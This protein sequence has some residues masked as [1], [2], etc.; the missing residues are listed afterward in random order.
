MGESLTV[1]QAADVRAPSGAAAPTA[2]QRIAGSGTTEA[3]NTTKLTAGEMA[4]LLVGKTRVRVA[5]K[6][7]IGASAQVS[8]T[9][10]SLEPGARVDWLV[11]KDLDDVVYAEAEDG[12]SAYEAWV[13]TSS[14]DRARS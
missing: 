7:V 3:H 11:E 5:W 12:S 1:I 14:G 4:T 9:S 8:S 2:Q 13:W 6:G 10:I